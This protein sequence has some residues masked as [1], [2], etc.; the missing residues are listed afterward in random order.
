MAKFRKISPKIWNDAKFRAL[1][2]NAKLVF[3]MLL[4]HPQTSAL[5]TLRAF[6]QGLAPEMGWSEKDFRKAFQ[7]VL[8]KGMA[9]CSEK[10]G[11]IWLPNFM[12]HNAPESPNVLRS[13]AGAM[14]DCPECSLKNEVF[15]AA[16]VFAEGLP[17]GFRKAFKESFRQPS[18]NQEQEQEQDK[19]TSPNG[20]VVGAESPTCC[21]HREI[22]AA[23]HECLPE[24]AR[25]KIW[26]GTRKTNLHARWKERWLARKY[27][28][29]PEGIA[30]WRRLFMH[31][32]DNC[33]FLMGRITGN[34][35]KPF[36]ADLAWLVCPENFAKLIEG[37][38][39][40]RPEA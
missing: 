1:S 15:Q 29:Q 21:P 20:E 13:W 22:V 38:Y 36:M 31:V 6:P 37:R 24:L 3:F 14:E 34:K 17:E 28:S 32:H 25:V 4:T 11:L 39:D 30:Y 12:R 9:K 10:D 16:K 5:G 23:Y 26:D 19:E 2:D 40:N 33:D 18:P 7:E 8:G 27:R 35:G